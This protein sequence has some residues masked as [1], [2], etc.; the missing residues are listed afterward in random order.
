[1]I[2]HKGL[3]V[4]GGFTGNHRTFIGFRTGSGQGQHRTH[5]DCAFH[6]ATAGLQ[7]MPWIDAVGI[8]RGCGDKFGAVED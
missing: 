2:V 7:D 1:M 4:T 8:M 6:V 3:F 5:R